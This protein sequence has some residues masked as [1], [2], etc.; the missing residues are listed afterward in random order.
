MH[1]LTE[2]F[3]PNSFPTSTEFNIVQAYFQAVCEGLPV[4]SALLTVNMPS[5]AGALAVLSVSSTA[6]PDP[7]TFVHVGSSIGSLYAEAY[8][9]CL[10]MESY[11]EVG[12]HQVHTPAMCSC[13][14]TSAPS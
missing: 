1:V 2:T 4:N 13:A 9:D 6:H 5:L 7:W 3:D 10:T 12:P 8:S 14:L 11:G